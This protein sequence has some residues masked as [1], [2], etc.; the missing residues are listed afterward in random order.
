M[1]TR[2]CLRSTLG[3]VTALAA[4]GATP[5][6]ASVEQDAAML[7][8]LDA[9]AA[10]CSRVSPELASRSRQRLD[11]MLSAATPLALTQARSHPAYRTASDGAAAELKKRA[12]QLGDL[13]EGWLGD[14]N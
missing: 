9:M 7:G 2:T 4:L 13:C 5:A 10:A 14:R 12:A 3:A 8:Q 11:V 6:H 1:K